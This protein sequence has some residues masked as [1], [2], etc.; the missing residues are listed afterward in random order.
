MSAL[1]LLAGGARALLRAGGGAHESDLTPAGSPLEVAFVWPADDLRLSLD[2]CPGQGAQARVAACREAL[3]A[4]L[5]PAQAVVAGRI[6]GWQQAHGARYG[7]WLGLRSG[8][9]A[10]GSKLYLEVPE[11]CSW[12]AWEAEVAG[13]PAVLPKRGIRPTMVGLDV[14]S[15]AIEIYYRCGRLYRGEIDTLLRRFRMDER[16]AEVVAVLEA[17]TRRTV[18]FELPSHDMGVSC[19]FGV[20]GCPRVFTWYS[21]CAALLGPPA[22]A[23][24]ALLRVGSEAGWPMDAYACL[25]AGGPSGEVPG[26][27]LIGAMLAEGQPLQVTATVAAAAHAAPSGQATGISSRDGADA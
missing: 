8:G 14:Q 2:P 22:R 9:G 10:L 12:S 16:G 7:A 15:G 13:A 21:T 25:T 4:P 26:H 17:L 5:S 6:E 11:A 24:D 23:R 20:D 27:G 18:R 19:S 1:S 3:T